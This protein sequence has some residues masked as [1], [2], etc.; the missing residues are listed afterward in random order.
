MVI[1]KQN[2]GACKNI[3]RYIYPPISDI[4]ISPTD[5]QYIGTPL[6]KHSCL[7]KKPQNCVLECFAVLQYHI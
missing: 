2:I 6:I 5:I 4:A 3:G 1:I 7:S